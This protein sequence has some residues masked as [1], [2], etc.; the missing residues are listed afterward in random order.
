MEMK[1]GLEM[2]VQLKT[3]EKLFCRC[4]AEYRDKKLNENICPICTGQSGSKPMLPNLEAIKNLLKIGLILNCKIVNKQIRFLRKHYF[5]PDL[6][7]NYQ[8]TSEPIMIEGNFF[9]IR[10]REIHIEED[11]R[12]YDLR[13]GFVDFNRSWIPLAEIVTELILIL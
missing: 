5:Y 13:D 7:K 4:S 6:P 10:I 12:G 1:V 2:H 9:G 3:K 11:P 8:I